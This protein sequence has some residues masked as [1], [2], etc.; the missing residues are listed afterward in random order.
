MFTLQVP[1]SSPRVFLASCC[2]PLASLSTWNSECDVTAA[3]PSPAQRTSFIPVM[4]TVPSKSCGSI[5]SQIHCTLT[6]SPTDWQHT[7]WLRHSGTPS[8]KRI[9][10]SMDIKWFLTRSNMPYK[11]VNLILWQ[12][13]DLTQWDKLQCSIQYYRL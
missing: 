5:P 10:F 3:V 12:L 13:H 7:L 4:T 6:N 11:P 9:N 8:S 2:L 1:P